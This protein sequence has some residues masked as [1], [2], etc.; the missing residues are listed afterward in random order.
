LH[1]IDVWQALNYKIII[2]QNEEE[3][4]ELKYLKNGLPFLKS[5]TYKC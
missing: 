5:A 2:N 4:L 1:Q 3:G